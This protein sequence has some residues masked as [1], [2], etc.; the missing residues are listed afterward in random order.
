MIKPV[1]TGLPVYQARYGWSRTSLW[2]LG[3]GIAC[4]ST[5][6]VRSAPL[7][8]KVLLVVS[9]VFLLANL[10]AALIG[11][12]VAFRA[13]QSG[14][15]LGGNP[16]P[17]WYQATTRFIPWTEIQRVT[18]WRRDFPLVIGKWTLCNLGPLYYIGLIR[19]PDAPLLSRSGSPAGRGDKPAYMAPPGI[20]AGAARVV[21]LWKLDR[22]R[23]DLA[24]TTFAPGVGVEEV[25]RHPPR[26]HKAEHRK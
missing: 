6:F 18:I 9:G 3:G 26:P 2:F 8:I 14:V 7:L 24:V 5:M 15:T 13:D 16:I 19:R 25:N 11:R 1:Q 17:F 22:H 23:L 10:L 20:A 21:S 4:T 12:S